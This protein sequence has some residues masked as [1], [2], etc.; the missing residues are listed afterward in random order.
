MDEVP[1]Y[2]M[3]EYRDAFDIFDVSKDG[4][5]T[6]KELAQ[7]M[8]SINQEPT[9]VE[10]RDMIGEVDYDKDGKINFDEFLLLMNSKNVEIDIEDEIIYAFQI[11][12]KDGSGFVTSIELRQILGSLGNKLTEDE[13]DNMI[14]EAD[15]DGDGYINYKEFVRSM[16]I[17]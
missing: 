10:L 6:I 13:I 15:I 4:Y 8:R 5:I 11:F 16:L 12:D 2:R 7:V 14:Y 17:K 9:E 3:K 1:D